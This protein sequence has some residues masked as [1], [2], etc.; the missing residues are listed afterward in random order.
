MKKQGCFLLICI[1]FTILNASSWAVTTLAGANCTYAVTNGWT[2]TITYQCDSPINLNGATIQFSVDN[3]SGLLDL[4]NVWGFTNLAWYPVNPRLVL[5]GNA[6]TLAL[7]FPVSLAVTLPANTPSSFSYSTN[8]TVK[9]TGFSIFASGSTATTGTLNFSQSNTSNDLPADT[10]IRI[11][12]VDRPFS[13]SIIFATQKNLT[14]IPF[15]TY[16]LSAKG[17]VNGQ[18]IPI[19]LSPNQ[20]TLNNNNATVPVTLT[21][22]SL[23]A[24]LT[25]SLPLN[26]PADINGTNILVNVID[27]LNVKQ[28]VNVPWKSQA[29]LSGLIAGA[30][31]TL[32]AN[33]INGQNNQYQFTFSPSS[34]IANPGQNN[35]AMGMIINPLPTGTANIV[36]TG[37]PAAITTS[38]LFTY[39]IDGIPQTITFRNVENGLHSY[40]LPAGYQYSL[41]SNPVLI[42]GQ[43]YTTS[44]QTLLI[45][46]NS[47]T[48][49]TLSFVASPAHNVSGWPTYLAMGAVTDSGPI[50]TASL[51][52]RPIDAVFKYGGFTGMGDSGQIVYPIF[53]M[54]TA[55]QAQLLSNYYQQNGFANIVK[56]VMVIY[57]AFMSNGAN[58]GDFDYGNLTMHFINLLME[59][60]KLQSY[61]SV[62]N[63]YPA[64][65][66][67][68]PDLLGL[69]QQQNLTA[70]INLMIQGYSLQKAI[71]TAV[72]FVTSTL[73]TEFGENLNYE[74][75]YRAIRAR[76]TDNW[77][78]MSIWDGFKMTYFDRCNANPTV[79]ANINV[80]AFTND[81]PGWVQANNWSIRQFAPNV[82]FGWQE[83]L[84]ATGTANW[85]HQN[86]TSTTLQTQI[87][88]PTIAGIKAT[89]AYSGNHSP[90]FLVFDK[91]EMDAIP[92]ASGPG[93][94]YNARDW[95]NVLAHV[96][97]V[98]E[99]LGNIPIMLWQIPGGHLQ[100]TTDID[101]RMNHASTEPDFFFG[102]INNPLLN[103]KSYIAN[104]TLTSSIYGTNN[105]LTY[106]SMNALGNGNNYTWIS[107]HL[108]L[109]ASSH[110]FAILWGGGGTT[111][112]GSFPSDDGGW[113]ANKIIAYYK[114]PVSLQ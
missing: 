26:K 40:T 8:N 112:V 28:T 73:T 36:V 13:T 2:Q 30:K 60:Q 37:L 61:K 9:V 92:S 42:N 53:D 99:G 75:L 51:K 76:T 38:L 34:L 96:K 72:C 3:P 27:S 65:I 29:T 70:D 14:N 56:P 11:S 18:P 33:A 35:V 91:Y 69:I 95:T 100:Q 97:N 110:V 93:Y 89:S 6:L 63:P 19:T 46:A 78:A 77:S 113:L 85:V 41:S 102:N 74:Q 10:T 7:K 58:M 25:I 44:T 111:S 98:S 88:A 114:S 79:P 49:A 31:Y 5:V 82:T 12:G 15:G 55:E 108:Q 86:Y 62:Q 106:L 43:R 1:L 48:S 64:S 16:Q 47:T 101:L 22:K 23:A 68:N 105:I 109:A 84:W 52:L 45:E 71:K 57:T 54:Q 83:N 24:S 39:T 87:S 90:D 4:N 32:T 67:L 107:S 103:L 81:L 104:L 21:Y 59:A 66:I 50:T 80:P 17:S 20:V 94:L